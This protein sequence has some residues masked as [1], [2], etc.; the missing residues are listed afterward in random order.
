MVVD[1]QGIQGRGVLA[2]EDR[3]M[4]EAAPR[5]NG[6]GNDEIEANSRHSLYGFSE[7]R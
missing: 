3:R 7:C 6:F 2:R 1:Q 5:P 4:G